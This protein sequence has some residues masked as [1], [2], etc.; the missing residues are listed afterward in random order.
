MGLAGEPL[1]LRAQ[2][3]LKIYK[4]RP[5]SLFETQSR[6][7]SLQYFSKYLPKI[8]EISY[9]QI[10][11]K[12]WQWTYIE[13][14]SWNNIKAVIACDKRLKIPN[15]DETLYMLSDASSQI[16]FVERNN[17]LEIVGANSKVFSYEDSLKALKQKSIICK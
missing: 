4:P 8:K 16:L 6:L 14:R 10:K 13:E 3:K 12:V 9:L 1:G 15:K 2:T 7:Y 11:L 17:Q 5:S